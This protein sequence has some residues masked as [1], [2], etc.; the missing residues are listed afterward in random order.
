MSTFPIDFPIGYRFMPTD[1]QLIGYLKDKTG[2][3]EIPPNTV[4]EENIYALEPSLL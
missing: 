4:I 2:G 3:V 1:Q